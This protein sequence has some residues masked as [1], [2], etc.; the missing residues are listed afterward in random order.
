MT[1]FYTKNIFDYGFSRFRLEYKTDLQQIGFFLRKR[2]ID[3][4]IHYYVYTNV[5]V[6]NA[7]TMPGSV[8]QIVF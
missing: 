4:Q 5:T 7:N 1:L 2:Y 6:L 3:F 8:C